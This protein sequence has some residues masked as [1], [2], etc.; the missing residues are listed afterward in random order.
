MSLQSRTRDNALRDI[1]DGN[2]N[3]DGVVGVNSASLL[4]NGE[5]EVLIEAPVKECADARVD[6]GDLE[7]DKIADNGERDPGCGNKAVLGIA[8]DEDIEFIPGSGIG[9]NR[10]AGEEDFTQFAA[11]EVE[12]RRGIFEDREGVAFSERGHVAAD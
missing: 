4:A 5:E 11:I 8:V 6:T 3:N 7:G 2:E 10:L 9:R 12:A 1:I